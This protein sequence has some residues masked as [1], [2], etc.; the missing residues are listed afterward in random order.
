MSGRPH[1]CALRAILGDR[2]ALNTKGSRI[3]K[4]N[5]GRLYAKAAHL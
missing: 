1:S 4:R 3:E 2:G 5:G